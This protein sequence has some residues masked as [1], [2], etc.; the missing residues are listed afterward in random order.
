MGDFGRFLQKNMTMCV[1]PKI[2]MFFAY[3]QENNIIATIF[4]YPLKN[5][6]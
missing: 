3:T 4:I 2:L 1:S 5:L 6:I